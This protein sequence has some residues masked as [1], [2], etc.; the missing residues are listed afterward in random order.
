MGF[1]RVCLYSFSKEFVKRHKCNQARYFNRICSLQR[2]DERRV[3]RGKRKVE[4]C[5][6]G[7]WWSGRDF[8]EGL[9]WVRDSPPLHEFFL[10]KLRSCTP[11]W[12]HP[13]GERQQ[14]MGDKGFKGQQVHHTQTVFTG[15]TSLL[16][17]LTREQLLPVE[18]LWRTT[19]KGPTQLSCFQWGMFS[20]DPVPT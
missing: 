7:G 17:S 2:G 12:C 14:D 16:H 4:K 9:P 15:L 3:W 1:N 11:S 19:P 5:R 20:W 13:E 6:T 8:P 10:E 18:Q